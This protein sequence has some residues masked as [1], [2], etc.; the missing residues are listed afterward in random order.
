MVDC[1]KEPQNFR[2]G[3]LFKK[4]AIKCEIAIGRR[5][6]MK[7]HNIMPENGFTA[8][9][10]TSFIRNIKRGDRIVIFN[11][12]VVFIRRQEEFILREFIVAFVFVV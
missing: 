8:F 12:I 1:V 9:I 3:I 2:K 7:R 5:Q 4:L 11:N 6:E 10:S